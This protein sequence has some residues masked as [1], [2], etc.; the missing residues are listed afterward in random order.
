MPAVAVAPR[1]WPGKP[2][3]GAAATGAGGLA[4]ATLAKVVVFGRV[5]GHV[6]DRHRQ[7]R[8]RTRLSRTRDPARRCTLT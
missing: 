1:S 6:R 4:L 7:A 8:S 3:R 5:L 2:E